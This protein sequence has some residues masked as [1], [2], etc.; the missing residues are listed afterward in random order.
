[1]PSVHLLSVGIGMGGCE[2]RRLERFLRRDST[3]LAL[4]KSAPSLVS[5]DEERMLFMMVDRT[6]LDPFEL[7]GVLVGDGWESFF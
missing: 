7:G 5:S 3:S 1:M 4:W 2:W 6:W